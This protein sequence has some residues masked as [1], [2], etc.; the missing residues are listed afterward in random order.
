MEKSSAQPKTIYH[1]HGDN[2]TSR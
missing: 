1:C 2:V